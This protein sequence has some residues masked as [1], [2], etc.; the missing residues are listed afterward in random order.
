MHFVKARCPCSAAIAEIYGKSGK[1]AQQYLTQLRSILMEMVRCWTYVN[2]FSGHPDVTDSNMFRV[3]RGIIAKKSESQE[4]NMFRFTVAPSRS[5]LVPL[6]VALGVV[7]ASVLPVHAG[8]GT[9][10]SGAFNYCVSVR[11]NATP[12]ELNQIR[13]AFQNGSDVLLDATDGQHR[14]GQITIVNDSGASQSAE[15]WVNSRAGRAYAT[16]GQYGIRGEHVNL[17]FDSNFQASRGA[18]GDAYTI[19]HEH[20]H[21]AYGV[22]DEYSGP[23]GDAEDAPTPETA[24]LNYSL[25]DNYFTR[26]GRSGGGTVYTLNEFCIDSNHDPDGDTWQED[27]YGESVWE[28]VAGQTR[29]PVIAP[30]G[31]PVDAPPASQA[32]TFVDGF[33]GLRAMLLLDRSGS[34]DLNQRLDFAKLGANQFV[35]LMQDGDGIGVASF[36]SSSAVNFALAT[37]T[38]AVRTSA[39]SAI[40]SLSANGQTNIGGGLLTALG[41]LTAQS[42]RSCNEVIILLSDGDHNTGTPPSAVI[43]AL[44]S[45]GITVLTIGLGSGISTSGQAALQAIASQ[46]GGRFYRAAS[47]ADLT[48]VFVQLAAETSGSGLLALAPEA[49]ASNEVLEHD[50]LVEPGVESAVFAVTQDLALDDISLSLRTP[51]GAIITTADASDPDIKVLTSSNS[52]VFEISAPEAGVWQLIVSAGTVTNGQIDFLAYARHDGVQLN[53][54]VADDVVEFPEEVAISARPLYEGE[55]VVG[56]AVQG[57]VKRPDGSEVPIMLKD[58][59]Q[60]ADRIAGDGIYAATFSQYNDNGTYV[61]DLTANASGAST[62]S[63]ESLFISAGDPSSAQQVPNFVRIANATAVVSGISESP[64]PDLVVQDLTATGSNLQVT[65]RNQGTAAVP[66][67]QGFWV[68][69]YVDPSV[70]PTQPNQIWNFLADEGLVWGVDGDVLPMEPS[71]VIT[72]TI[73]DAL[74]W[75]DLSKFSGALPPGTPIYVQVDSANTNTTYG[76]VLE[77]HEAAGAAY[78]NVAGPI[79]AVAAAA[80]QT[81]YLPLL[82]TEGTTGAAEVSGPAAEPEPEIHMLPSRVEAGMEN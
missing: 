26:G 9:F 13:T 52:T 50:V 18:D 58:D 10:E 48:N 23:A 3:N 78:N 80:Y 11:F 15:Y 32:V 35:D 55:A 30:S 28:M 77:S 54:S 60:G 16:Y 57:S 73:G 62:Y 44:N 37:V 42:N 20:S 29:F 68:D 6:A 76:G 74:Y 36:E 51:S 63:G 4:I 45:E 82:T 17:Y 43:P 33:G 49:V 14:F 1:T 19:A 66:A 24:T 59:G 39:K 7:L 38:G 40:G 46:T 81:F 5:F 69:L 41:Q 61:F 56:A 70:V 53:V 67:D 27:M 22:A 79:P 64:R 31:L 71:E 2:R 47:A 12:A 21:H 8:N 25:M 34:M 72:L 75:P 65:I